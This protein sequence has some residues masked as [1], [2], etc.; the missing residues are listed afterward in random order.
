[1]QTRIASSSLPSLPARPDQ[2]TYIIQKRPDE[3][4]ILVWLTIQNP[5]PL[6]LHR[7]GIKLNLQ[8]MARTAPFRVR[9]RLN[10]GKIDLDE[11]VG[12]ADSILVPGWISILWFREL[13]SS[14]AYEGAEVPVPVCFQVD[15]E[16]VV[17]VLVRA[18]DVQVCDAGFDDLG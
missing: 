3:G 15:A 17:E 1:M 4:F 9:I 2:Y 10:L 6:L 8:L 16:A 14:I 7:P 12:I 13:S 18:G 5:L 11:L